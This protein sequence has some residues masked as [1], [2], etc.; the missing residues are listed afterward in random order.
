MIPHTLDQQLAVQNPSTAMQQ[1]NNF[2]QDSSLPLEDRMVMLSRACG[3][4]F[5]IFGRLGGELDRQITISR[6]K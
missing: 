2:L 3:E 1:M 5:Q 6:T 4:A